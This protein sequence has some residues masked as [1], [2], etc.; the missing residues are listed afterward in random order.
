MTRG[1]VEGA[2]LAISRRFVKKFQPAEMR[3]GTRG[4]EGMGEV[5]EDLAGVVDVVWRS[6]TRMC[7]LAWGE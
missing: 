6:G 7:I 4:Y 2:L 1:Y 5:C 3:G